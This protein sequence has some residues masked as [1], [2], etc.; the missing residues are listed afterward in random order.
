LR[1]CW[2]LERNRFY[3]FNDFGFW[4]RTKVQ[5]H[6]DVHGRVHGVGEFVQKV[7]S[8]EK[9]GWMDGWCCRGL[10][11]GVKRS[12]TKGYKMRGIYRIGVTGRK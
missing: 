7:E 8:R 4:E 2:Q 6:I 5:I 1:H 12:L 11:T 3:R 9:K 10:V